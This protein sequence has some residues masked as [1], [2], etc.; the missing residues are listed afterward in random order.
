[1]SVATGKMDGEGDAKPR[2]DSGDW[3][4]TEKKTPLWRKIVP[5]V[6]AAGL[7][8]LAFRNIDFPAFAAALSKLN[9][10]AFLGFCTIWVLVLLASDSLG[11]L[12]AYRGSAPGV[13]FFDF[14]M[15]RGASYLPGIVNHHVG[16]AYMTYMFHKLFRLPLARMAG[17]T[18]LSYAGWMGCLVLCMAVALPFSGLSAPIWYTPAL[19]GAGVLYLVVIAAKPAR[20]VKIGFLAPLFEAGIVGH[21]V[22]LAARLPHLFIL[23]LG[24]WVSFKFFDVHIPIGT[25]MTL[26]PIVLVAV[27][28]PITPQ[29][30]GTRDMLSQKFFVMFALGA[31]EPE[32][33]GRVAAC[34]TSFG[35]AAT[36]LGGLVGV[37]A[38]RVTNR[39]LAEQRASELARSA[40]APAPT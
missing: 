14:Y 12:T 15:L 30:F 4:E 40:E 33:L 5:F 21:A 3:R 9:Y 29:G 26:L 27:T 11:T 37:I 23:V 13:R 32:R 31:T 35:V 8:F 36:L 25:A 2:L 39:R 28:L 34:T 10:V 1:M 22:A 16:Q 38:M 24:N 19:L 6:V 7:L 18:L 17:A 20:L